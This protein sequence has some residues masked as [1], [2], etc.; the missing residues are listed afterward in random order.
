MTIVSTPQALAP[1]LSIASGSP[2]TLIEHTADILGEAHG[3]GGFLFDRDGRLIAENGVGWLYT[4]R[5]SG[6]RWE[7]WVR[8]FNLNTLQP[9]PARCVL[10]PA[11]GHDRAVLHHIVAI[12][13]DFI[14]GFFCDGV[15][16]SVGIAAAPDDDFVHD[17]TFVLRPE[18]GWETRGGS[19][20]GWS[21]ESNGAYSLCHDNADETVFWQ[22]YDS[23][24]KDGRLGDLGWAKVRVD[25]KTCRVELLERHSDNPLPF[26][27]PE[28]LCARCGGNLSSDVTIVGKRA[29]F[30]YLRPNISE[31]FVGLALSD[32][33]LFF[34]HVSH[35]IVD[36]VLDEE[37]VAEKFQAVQRKDG[38]LIFYESRFADGSWRTGLRRYKI[39]SW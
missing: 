5:I 25:K 1:A 38:L 14:V 30:Y 24:R 23:Y 12:A 6:G 4:T 15:G 17:P 22:G 32:D 19:V 3:F 27:N 8:P 11:A 26:R 20:E 39:R 16:I 36:T 35:W 28:W 34:Q 31:M 37:T 7:S 18:I 21:L 33:P 13:D 2:L 10:Q 29:F 9:G